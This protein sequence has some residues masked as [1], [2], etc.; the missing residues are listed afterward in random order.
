MNILVTNDDGYSTGLEILL[1]AAGEIGNA[2][3]LIPEKQKSA[4]SGAMTLHKPLR[5]N[6]R[7]DNIYELS[8]TPADCVLFSLYSKELPVPDIVFSGI[9]WGDNAGMGPLIGSGT[10]GACWQ[11]MLEGIPGIAFSRYTRHRNWRNPDSWGDKELLFRKT[12]EISEELIDKL[13]GDESFYTVNYPEKIENDTKIVETKKL[14]K[15]RFKTR[16]DKKTDPNNEPYYWISGSPRKRENG[17]D[18]YEISEKGNISVTRI[19][20]EYFE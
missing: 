4:V 20:M 17:T 16:V 15:R 9:N 2:Y 3:A 14:Q 12:L 5:L 10:L 1:R 13:D 6:Q 11:G 18:L 8:G 19:S 7:N